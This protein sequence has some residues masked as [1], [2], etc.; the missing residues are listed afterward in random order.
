MMGAKAGSNIAAGEPF[1]PD[2]SLSRMEIQRRTVPHAF[3]NGAY[4]G[5]DNLISMVQQQRV[6]RNGVGD[7]QLGN[8]GG[9]PVGLQPRPSKPSSRKGTSDPT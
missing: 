6:R 4:P 7:L 3:G 1:S 5:L 8:I 2:G 9:L